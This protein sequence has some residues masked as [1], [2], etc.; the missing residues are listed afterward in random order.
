MHS[1]SRSDF[2]QLLLALFLKQRKEVLPFLYLPGVELSPV[3]FLYHAI[4]R[5]SQ[6]SNCL[7][8]H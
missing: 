7:L 5:P 4:I 3:P 2:Q 1:S 6:F 8:V